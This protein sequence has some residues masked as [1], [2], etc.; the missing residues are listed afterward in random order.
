MQKARRDESVG[1][2]RR[3]NLIMAKRLGSGKFKGRLGRT[4]GRGTKSAEKPL[5]VG[6]REPLCEKR[7]KSPSFS[8]RTTKVERLLHR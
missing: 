4:G 2:R 5:T 6:E 1:S 7:D 3:L 8:R